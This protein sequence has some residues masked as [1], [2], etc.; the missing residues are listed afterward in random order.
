LILAPSSPRAYVS[1][2]NVVEPAPQSRRRSAEEL[3]DY[4]V[5]IGAALA[6]CGCPS[7]RVEEAIHVVAAAE[8]RRAQAFVLPTGLFLR[9]HGDSG[10][11][12]EFA[13][14][15]RVEQDAHRMVRVHAWSLD[16][17]DLVAVDEI[18]NDVAERRMSIEDARAAIRAIPTRPPT[19]P[20]PL[21]WLANS[22]VSGAAAVFFGG[23]RVDVVVALAVGALLGLALAWLGRAPS[24]QLLLEFSAGVLAA[25]GA[26][27]ALLVRPDAHPEIVVLAAT[28][29]FFPGMTF[30]TGLAEL[31]QKNL[32][33]GGARLMEAFMTLLHLVLGVALVIG[34][35][36][37]AQVVVP[38]VTTPPPGLPLAWQA[39]A[40]VVS[41]VG[42]GV[43]LSV[44]RRYL[45][46]AIVSG[47]AAYLA[48]TLAAHRLPAH[49]G[50][51]LGAF[52]VCMLANTLARVTKRPA[53]LFQ[54]PG[55]L[56]LV[57]GSFGFVALGAF[58]RGDLVGGAT[59]GFAM[60]LVGGALVLG[61]MMANALLPPR[62]VL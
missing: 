26:S 8:H 27:A 52:A 31:A 40:L 53:Q 39:A 28:I 18:F 48:T 13:E 14:G 34:V 62:K 47:A 36:Q 59:R 16:L 38:K 46:S 17:A 2:V 54:L 21:V 4:L 49:L 32:V 20:A 61:V 23:T 51:F 35:R 3:A 29:T 55:M 19:Y 56:L 41:A 5:E 45:W 7:Y 12:G 11:S 42:F 43:V 44:P 24:R 58:L 37:M 15:A 6:G 25:T 33:S 10:D 57:P 60:L 50:A 9:V 30:T 1:P 22:L